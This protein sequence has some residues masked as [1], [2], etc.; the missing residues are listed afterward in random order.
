MTLIAALV[1]ASAVAV[2][3]SEP[4]RPR[5]GAVAVARVVVE[6]LPT[7]RGVAEP[8]Q[9]EPRRQVRRNASGQAIVE[10]E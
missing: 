9:P 6:I 10:F 2:P 8:D 3:P 7:A 5:G 4:Q 1:L